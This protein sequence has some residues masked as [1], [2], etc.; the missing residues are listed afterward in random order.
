MN[1]HDKAKLHSNVL[2]KCLTAKEQITPTGNLSPVVTKTSPLSMYN[3][4]SILETVPKNRKT[5]LERRQQS[6]VSRSGNHGQLHCKFD[7][8]SN[9]K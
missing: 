3:D 6:V 9:E 2:H 8:R 5:T 4:E 7:Y 1:D